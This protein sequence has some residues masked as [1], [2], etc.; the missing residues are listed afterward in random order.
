MLA[1]FL[2]PGWP[3]AWAA[4]VVVLLFVV[5]WAVG[6]RAGDVSIVDAF[7]G[8]AF[9]L[10]AA[11]VALSASGDSALRWVLLGMTAVWGLRL[12]GFLLARFLR[13]DDEDPRYQEIRERHD[14]HFAV[15]SL[16]AIFGTQALAVLV[17]SLPIQVVA[18][19]RDAIDAS[20]VAGLLVW[21]F[22]VVVEGVADEQQRRFS[23]SSDDDVLDTGL[24]RY[25]RHPN[26]F[27]DCCAWWGIWLVAATVDGAWW[28]A[29][30]PLLMTIVLVRGTA[31][32][33]DSDG[34]PARE[35]YERR[36]SRF[37]L[38]PPRA[39]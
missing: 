37:V 13:H 17:V 38:L 29:V 31:S 34:S 32:G 4:G 10:V 35:R 7:W 21:A 19:S 30:G 5:V 39:A 12:G 20:V 3:T 25:S 9:V 36:T 18:V 14:E 28:T 1:A 15:F 24:W 23:K 26:K 16:V 27:G 33:D 6:T 2:A 11:T 22:G 8:P